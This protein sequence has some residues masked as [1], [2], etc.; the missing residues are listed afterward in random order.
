M[1]TSQGGSSR[2]PEAGELMREVAERC[3]QTFNHLQ[4]YV[5]LDAR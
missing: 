3:D 5:K 4:F 1:A 2:L